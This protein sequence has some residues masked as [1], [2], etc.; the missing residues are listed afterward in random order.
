MSAG[1]IERQEYRE[2]PGGRSRNWALLL[3]APPFVGLLYVPFYARITPKLWGIPFFVWY[4]FL[5][6]VL[7]SALTA[8]VYLIRR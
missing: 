2:R 5:W 7:G 1:D 3:L 8:L 4:Q 6:I